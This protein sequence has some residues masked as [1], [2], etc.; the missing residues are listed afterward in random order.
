MLG[1]D[2]CR[3]QL[4][5]LHHERIFGT[6]LGT[7]IFAL[8]YDI[9]DIS[10]SQ[11]ATQGASVKESFRISRRDT[12]HPAKGRPPIAYRCPH[13]SPDQPFPAFRVGLRIAVAV[14]DSLVM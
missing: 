8:A 6:G 7:L 5:Q 4:D 12:T 13:A 2:A 3:L 1:L 9:E 11:V 14:K 10:K